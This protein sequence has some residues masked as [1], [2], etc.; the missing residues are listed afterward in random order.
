MVD[1]V[2]K[3]NGMQVSCTC[4]DFQKRM[5][6]STVRVASDNSPRM[7]YGSKNPSRAPSPGLF[8]WLAFM[9]QAGENLK[10]IC[11]GDS[12]REAMRG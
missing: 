6:G 3:T 12:W 10:V 9:E 4:S 8:L 5:L 11:D 1:G 7:S 2:S